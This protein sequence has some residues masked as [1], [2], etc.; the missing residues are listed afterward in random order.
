M[1]LFSKTALKIFLIFCFSVEDNMAYYLSQMVFL[2][3]V[4]IPDYRG[5]K[6]GVFDFFDLFSKVTQNIFL[7]FWMR[8]REKGPIV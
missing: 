5:S 2:K 3:K 7:I 4:L 8:V 1:G 6:K